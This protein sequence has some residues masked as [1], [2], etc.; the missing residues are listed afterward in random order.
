MLPVLRINARYYGW[1]M[2]L[3]IALMLFVSL[4][5]ASLVMHYSL[6]SF[7]ALPTAENWDAPTDRAHFELNYGFVLNI[8][9][10]SFAALLVD[11]LSPQ[12]RA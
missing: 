11:S 10:L 4:V 2:S 1:K 8:I 12:N 9:F 3:Y 6:L 5:A 7:D